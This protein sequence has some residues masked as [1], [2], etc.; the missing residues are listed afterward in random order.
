MK[1]NCCAQPALDPSPRTASSAP[2]PCANAPPSHPPSRSPDGVDI[3]L[4]TPATCTAYA[5][6]NG[7]SGLACNALRPFNIGGVAYNYLGTAAALS[8]TPAQPPCGPGNSTLP[9]AA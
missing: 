9:V 3:I 2:M 6:L 4:A 1:L 7:G 8:M 5:A